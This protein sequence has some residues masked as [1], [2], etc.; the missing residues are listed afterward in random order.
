ME[1]RQFNTA[2][3]LKMN[4]LGPLLSKIG[5]LL[6]TIEIDHSTTEITRFRRTSENNEVGH[7]GG[8]HGP[9]KGHP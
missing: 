8:F 6:S 4:E 5:V 7:F 2:W 1:R 9:S 3:E